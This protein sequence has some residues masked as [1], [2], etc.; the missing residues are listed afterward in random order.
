MKIQK[1]SNNI[2][3][4]STKKSNAERV[5][6][7]SRADAAAIRKEGANL[8]NEAHRYSMLFSDRLNVDLNAIVLLRGFSSEKRKRE[9]SD[10][11]MHRFTEM[12]NKVYN[13][14]LDLREFL[15]KHRQILDGV[16]ATNNINGDRIIVLSSG[17]PK[18]ADTNEHIE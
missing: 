3:Q 18:A 16:I 1:E 4:P 14:V 9:V 12:Q 13:A 15:E 11:D 17:K 2:Q 5:P 8:A 6:G 10:R 7:Q